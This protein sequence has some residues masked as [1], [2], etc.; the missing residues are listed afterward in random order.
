MCKIGSS[1]FSVDGGPYSW[2][3]EPFV[4][5][6]REGSLSP[7]PARKARLSPWVGGT[8]HAGLLWACPFNLDVAL[9]GGGDD[10]LPGCSG[11]SYTSE[12]PLWADKPGC[13]SVLHACRPCLVAGCS[14]RGRSS[15]GGK[16]KRGEEAA[17][18]INSGKQH[19][20]PSES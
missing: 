17:A 14:V 6:T 4:S 1:G 16:K 5:V 9:A 20:L 8:R 3:G 2:G 13:P 15:R 12:L 19:S 10:S 7:P 18:A 11:L